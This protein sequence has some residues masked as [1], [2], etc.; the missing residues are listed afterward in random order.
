MMMTAMIM[1]IDEINMMMIMIAKL[2]NGRLLF[3]FGN[4]EVLKKQVR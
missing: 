3:V 1:M 4:R 2:K